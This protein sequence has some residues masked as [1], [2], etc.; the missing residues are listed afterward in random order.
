[1]TEI[2]KRSNIK[3]RRRDQIKKRYNI[4]KVTDIPTAKGI[5]IQQIQAKAQ[6]IG[7][8]EKRNKH[9]RQN[10]IFKEDAKT[11]Y[12]ELGK[13]KIDVDEPPTSDEVEQFWSEIWEN[14][15]SHNESA[16]WIRKQEE[17]H[18]Q[19]ESQPWRGIDAHEVT[20]AIK[21]SSTW[22]SPGKEKATNVWL[23]HLVSIHGDVSKAYTNIIEN[24][25]ETPEWLTED[26]TYLLPKTK[27]TSSPKNYKPITCLPIMCKILTSI[28]AER[29]YIFLIEHQLLPT[30][31]V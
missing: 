30:T 16:E 11:C 15:K 21:K 23:K 14:D 5:L 20:L 12:R 17:L 29:T 19:R 25:E 1:M 31:M 2:E 18:K 24:P 7:R 10:K 9:F 8:F 28:I 3:G 27:E 4:K 22:K 13:K 26:L 6:R